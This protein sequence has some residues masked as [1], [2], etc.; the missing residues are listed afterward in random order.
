MFAISKLNIN[1]SLEYISQL[2]EKKKQLEQINLFSKCQTFK[3][4]IKAL[5]NVMKYYLDPNKFIVKR[6]FYF[7]KTFQNKTKQV[8]RY[9]KVLVD[10]RKIHE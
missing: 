5:I 3:Y 1:S 6:P 4:A 8:L 7:T 2:F 9:E 10:L